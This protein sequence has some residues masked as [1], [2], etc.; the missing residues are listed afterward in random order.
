MIG[1]PYWMA[2]E[3]VD[4][5]ARQLGGYNSKAD[6]WSLG[7]T[8]IECA[9]GRPPLSDVYPMKAIFLIPSRP[10]PTLDDDDDWSPN[11][12]DFVKRCLHK[13]FKSRPSAEDL[14]KHPFV[15]GAPNQ[16][17]VATLVEKCLPHI[18]AARKRRAEEETSDSET[19]SSDDN[20][21]TMT[22]TSSSRY[23]DT[24]V[25]TMR[26]TG[27][28]R[29]TETVAYSTAGGGTMKEPEYMKHIRE[30]E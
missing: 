27:T 23:Y 2:P 13:E 12:K 15:T 25:S 4:S 7:I 16:K 10:P 8:A 11:F 3:V 18:E 24:Q 28:M 29:T 9:Q 1:T 20:D 19:S 6:I 17:L 30:N 26:T 14:L 22:R 21:D 5:K